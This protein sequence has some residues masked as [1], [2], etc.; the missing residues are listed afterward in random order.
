M[1]LILVTLGVLIGLTVVSDAT[2]A[3]VGAV[4]A[5]GIWGTLMAVTF[6]QGE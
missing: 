2:G 3:I 1:A 5:L 4:I 6:L